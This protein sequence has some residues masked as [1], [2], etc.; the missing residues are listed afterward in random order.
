MPET[1]CTFDG[2]LASLKLRWLVVHPCFFHQLDLV[3]M[4]LSLL[5]PQI[6]LAKKI[7]LVRVRNLCCMSLDFER[8]SLPRPRRASTLGPVVS[9]SLNTFV[10]FK[11][12]PG[13][14]AA[15]RR[16]PSQDVFQKHSI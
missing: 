8:Y 15:S 4:I 1:E 6:F 2:G 14:S 9:S 5:R 12:D 11:R 7:L 10:N 16:G 3:E 13:K